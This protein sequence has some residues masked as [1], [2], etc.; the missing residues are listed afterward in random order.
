[1]YCFRPTLS[2][3]R[4]PGHVESALVIQKVLQDWSAESTFLG[5]DSA[6]L[7]A[8]VLGTIPPVGSGTPDMPFPR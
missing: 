7:P 5:L 8:I 3:G 1:M 2:H 4:Y 6:L